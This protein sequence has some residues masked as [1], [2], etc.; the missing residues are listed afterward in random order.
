MTINE[1]IMLVVA[2][3]KNILK[4]SLKYCN[5]MNFVLSSDNIYDAKE[6]Y[7]SHNINLKTNLITSLDTGFDAYVYSINYNKYDNVFNSLVFF[8][9]IINKLYYTEKKQYSVIICL[10]KKYVKRALIIC[11]YLF[12]NIDSLKIIYIN[13]EPITE[14]D[15]QYEKNQ[16]NLFY[17]SYYY[18]YRT[19]HPK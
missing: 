6:Y 2:N 14:D 7:S 17:Q 4:L 11:S 3:N 13:T 1:D 15:E 19:N 12:R 9:K 5:N 16:L 18:K 10:E 8:S